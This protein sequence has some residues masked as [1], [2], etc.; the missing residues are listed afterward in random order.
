MKRLFALLLAVVMTVCAMTVYAEEEPEINYYEDYETAIAIG[1]N[2]CPIS[3]DYEYTVFGF[4]PE[5]IGKYTFTAESALI[6]LASTNGMWVTVELNSETICG[7]SFVWNCT[8]VGQSIMFAIKGD[9]EVSVNITREDIIIVEIP[10]TPYENKTT[11]AP[12]K[13]EGEKGRLEYVDTFDETVN[14]AVLGEDGFYHLDSAEGPVLYAKLDDSL[15]SLAD[16]YG[17][18]Q[19]VAVIYENGEVVKK[20]DYNAAFNEYYLCSDDGLYPLTDDIIEIYREM[21]KSNSWY[22]AD[23]WVGGE[24]EDAW[25]FACYYLTEW[26]GLG[27][28]NNDGTI[29]QYD[30]L[31]VKRDYFGT[32]IMT[33]EEA[34]RADVNS[35]GKIDAYDYLLIA[36]HYF[37]TYV[38]K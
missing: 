11:P 15:M 4:Y 8:A 17:Y 2:K 14:T 24:Y 10:R 3:S 29:N 22:G 20:I 32:R 38:I 26:S 12:F 30:Y 19:I 18:G 16:A 31:L 21:G 5:E 28:V 7:E 36:R 13:F 37:G 9:S 6:G 1:E 35:D 34:A 23:G 33:D 25:M 27:D